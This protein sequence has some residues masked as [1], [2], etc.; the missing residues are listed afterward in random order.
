MGERKPD[1]PEAAGVRIVDV[2]AVSACVRRQVPRVPLGEM[3]ERRRTSGMEVPKRS[4]TLGPGGPGQ[5]SLAHEGITTVQPIPVN[6][7]QRSTTGLRVGTWSS[8]PRTRNRTLRPA[9]SL[10][11]T[12]LYSCRL[13]AEFVDG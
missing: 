13:P 5:S 8:P 9:L 2:R 11:T 7:P 10:L 1:R 6:H 4:S 12:A 3:K